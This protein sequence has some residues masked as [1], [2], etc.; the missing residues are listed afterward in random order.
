MVTAELEIQGERMPFLHGAWPDLALGWLFAPIDGGD[1]QHVNIYAFYSIGGTFRA[2]VEIANGKRFG[3]VEG[4]LKGTRMVLS[5]LLEGEFVPLKRCV[6]FG[7]KLDEEIEKLL[8]IYSSSNTLIKTEDARK[9]IT[10]AVLFEQKLSHELDHLDVYFIPP[11]GTHSTL[12]LIEKAETNLPADV[13]SRLS[14]R[15]LYDIQ[16][17]GRCLAFDAPTAAGFHIVRAVESQII[18][19]LSKVLGAPL[20]FGKNRNWG[21]YIKALRDNN[22]DVGV[23]NYLQHMKDTYRNPIIHPEEVLT[24]DEAFSLFNASLS[25][26]VQLDAAIEAWP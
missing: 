19:Y 3:D 11:K 1:M 15:S 23:T 26:I 17:A 9:L 14:P 5:R 20:N 10:A 8:R 13:V 2:L 24:P 4:L 7:K 18:R 22:A 21:A 16:Q 12:A 6:P 25:A